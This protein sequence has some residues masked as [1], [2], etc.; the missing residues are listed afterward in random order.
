MVTGVRH[1]VAARLMVG[2]RT[3]VAAV[4]VCARWRVRRLI[5]GVGLILS[6]VAGGNLR[7]FGPSLLR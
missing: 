2:G 7:G 4:M 1:M 6:V 3:M 5:V